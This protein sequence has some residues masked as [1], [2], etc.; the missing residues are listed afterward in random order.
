MNKQEKYKTKISS[1]EI[2]LVD[3]R[4]NEEVNGVLYEGIYGINVAKVQEIIQMPET[5]DLPAS[6]DYVVGVFDLRGVIIPLIDLAVWLKIKDRE[7]KIPLDKKRVIIAEFNNLKIGFLVHEAKLIRRIGWDK[8]QAAQFSSNSHNL[9]RGKI[10]GTTQIEDGKTLLILDLEGITDDLDFYSDKKEKKELSNVEK[11]FSGNVLIVDDST[12]ARS[13]LKKSLRK[14]GFTVIEAHDGEM[15]LNT[16][17]ELYK[18]HPDMVNYLRFIVSDIEMPKMD[19]FHFAKVVKNDERFQAIPL[20]FNSSICDKFSEQKGKDIGADAY[21]V[22]FDAQTF[23]NEI[24][25][26][27]E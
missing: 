21:L 25:K 2:E 6:P 14:M 11:T 18:E 10:T 24:S 3:F 26:I 13:L 7:A 16:L 5:F 27:L 22:K 12:I 4:I 15:A 23:Y 9:E 17:N 8:V 20:I 19:G 1:N